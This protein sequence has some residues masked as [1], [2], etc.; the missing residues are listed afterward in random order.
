MINLYWK[1]LSSFTNTIKFRPLCNQS[2]KLSDSQLNNRS[3]SSV[4]D[5]FFEL[6]DKST[7]M[8]SYYEYEF[9]KFFTFMIIFDNNII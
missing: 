7:N 2:N 9:N 5:V 4:M 3:F 1:I 8:R 6:F